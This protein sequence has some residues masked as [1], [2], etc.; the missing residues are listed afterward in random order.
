MNSLN[1]KNKHGKYQ[2]S[3][4]AATDLEQYRQGLIQTLKQFG[5]HKKNEETKDTTLLDDSYVDLKLILYEGPVGQS[6]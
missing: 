1:S 6:R 5:D 3:L 4:A 2:A